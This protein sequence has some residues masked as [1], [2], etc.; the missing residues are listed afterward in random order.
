MITEIPLATLL[1]IIWAVVF[2]MA[3]CGLSYWAAQMRDTGSEIINALT[4]PKDDATRGDPRNSEIGRS[5]A[6]PWR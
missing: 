5:D 4:R 6:P 1:S 3:A 2:V